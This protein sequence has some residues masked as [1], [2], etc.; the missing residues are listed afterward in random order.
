MKLYPETVR[1]GVRED[2]AAGQVMGCEDKEP[3][4]GAQSG[5]VPGSS[6]QRGIV[7]PM[8]AAAPP[9]QS[10]RQMES[11]VLG[12]CQTEHAAAHQG[13]LLP[14]AITSSFTGA[15]FCSARQQL[16]PEHPSSP[17]S[18]AHTRAPLHAARGQTIQGLLMQKLKKATAVFF[19]D[20]IIFLAILE[21][22][23]LR[24]SIQVPKSL[25][26]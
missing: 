13:C 18:A 26:I 17:R 16:S 14:S 19:I 3:D 7:V 11:P 10:P 2:T 8:A 21:F 5:A 15:R 6:R 9:G 20:Y 1:R 4:M 24:I 23:L 12:V 25:N 22:L